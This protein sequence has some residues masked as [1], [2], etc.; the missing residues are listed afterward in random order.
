MNKYYVADHH[1]V[2]ITPCSTEMEF[3]KWKSVIINMNER[4]CH[5]TYWEARELLIER[6]EKSLKEA[7]SKRDRACAITLEEPLTSGPKET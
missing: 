7:K 5:T 3:S 6:T 2:D 4:T 1:F